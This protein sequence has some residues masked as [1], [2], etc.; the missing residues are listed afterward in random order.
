MNEL[1]RTSGMPLGQQPQYQPCRRA[2]DSGLRS[3]TIPGC[4]LTLSVRIPSEAFLPSSDCPTLNKVSAER[5]VNHPASAGDDRECA[6]CLAALSA[7]P[8]EVSVTHCHH[9]FHTRC[10]NLSLSFNSGCPACK[11]P[12]SEQ[13][14]APVNIDRSAP[15]NLE[16]CS[17]CM[18][19]LDSRA[20][21]VLTVCDCAFHYRCLMQW[22]TRESVCPSCHAV[23][24]EQTAPPEVADCEDS[25]S[26]Q[27]VMEV[28]DKILAEFY[29][30]DDR[31]QEA[32]VDQGS[33][34]VSG[35]QVNGK[36][37]AQ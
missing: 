21:V 28:M 36:N 34:C 3:V 17:I 16:N 9:R 11:T 1:T 29:V 7:P 14:I 18:D 35:S 27:Q 2:F 33:S 6:I 23:L 25:A 5:V 24:V 4:R 13:T 32:S 22:L 26:F 20:A 8:K 37:L 10:L 30:S 31:R 12:L 15:V 19:V